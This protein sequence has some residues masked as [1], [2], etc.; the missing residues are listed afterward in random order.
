[1]NRVGAEESP[2][3]GDDVRPKSLQ[4]L[5]RRSGLR[6]LRQVLEL[7]H[8]LAALVVEPRILD[9][10]GHERGARDE[11]L[12][13]GV[14]ELTRRDRVERERPDRIAALAEHRDRDERLELLLLELGDVLDARVV[15]GVVADE[16]RLSPVERP[17]GEPLAA[18][19][20]DLPGEG[21]VRVGR[22]A[23][24]ELLV[25][26]EQ[27]DEARVDRARVGEEPDDPVEHFLEIQRRPDRRD[28]LVEEAPLDR[29]CSLSRSDGPSLRLGRFGVYAAS[30]R[31][32]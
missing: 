17:P 26:L 5:G 3:A 21:R 29:M 31:R 15:E 22:G 10:A 20:H 11:E 14:G 19:E 27:I 32:A 24:D 25:A 23:E 13:L 7:A 4:R 9:R 6:E 18:F 2:A 1:M 8:P 28:D 30:E 16:R 12:D